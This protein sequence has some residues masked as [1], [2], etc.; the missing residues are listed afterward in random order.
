MKQC[1]LKNQELNKAMRRACQEDS[2]PFRPPRPAIRR[3]FFPIG[4]SEFEMNAFRCM[5]DHGIRVNWR[6][7]VR[8]CKGQLWY[9]MCCDYCFKALSHGETNFMGLNCRKV[10][11]PKDYGFTHF[12][13]LREE[14]KYVTLVQLKAFLVVSLHV[15]YNLS[16]PNCSGTRW[17]IRIR[18]S[19][20]YREFYVYRLGDAHWP[21]LM[22][23]VP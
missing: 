16:I 3:A 5:Q 23:W 18:Q 22:T 17:K 13:C 7:S 11:A 10:L 12:L 19:S 6:K 2:C 15:Q 9:V 8:S 21:I 14:T 1:F 20:D 4:C